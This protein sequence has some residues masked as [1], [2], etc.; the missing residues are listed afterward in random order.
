MQLVPAAALLQLSGKSPLA[1]VGLL[2]QFRTAVQQV[3]DTKC[4]GGMMLVKESGQVDIG[5]PDVLLL[6]L[7]HH[8]GC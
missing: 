1:M 3:E 5:S 4:S 2:V 8:I 7:S 6:L